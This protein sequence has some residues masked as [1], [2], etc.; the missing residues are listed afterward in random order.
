[1]EDIPLFLELFKQRL[2]DT[3]LQ[4]WHSDVMDT[5]KL[6]TYSIHKINFCLETYLTIDM[7]HKHRIE[8]NQP[9]IELIESVNIVATMG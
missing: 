6:E 4:N 1:M 7:Y 5:R 3:S 8:Y 2:L 9:M